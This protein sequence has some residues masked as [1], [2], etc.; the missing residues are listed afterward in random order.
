MIPKVNLEERI[1]DI[2]EEPYQPIEVAK[3]NDQVVRMVLCRGNYHWHKHADEDELFYVL[4][5][6]LTIQLKEPYSN[7]ILHEGELTVI[8]KGVEHCPKSSVDTYILLF[9][10][11]TLKSRGDE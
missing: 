7:I 1:K 3:V 5:G 2:G 6:E 9:E 11:Y 8:P 10:P 4:R